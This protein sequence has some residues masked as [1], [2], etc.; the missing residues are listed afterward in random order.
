VIASTDW[1]TIASFATAVGTLVLAAATF[2]A[3]RSSNRSARIAEE[4][5][6]VNLRPVL[7]T[8]R[9]D[10]PM[11][12]LRWVD[13]HWARLDGS[14]ASVEM[15]NGSIYLA[16]SLRNVGPGLGVIFGWS[17]LTELV[18]TNEIPHAAPED[19]RMQTRDLYIAPGDIGFWQAAIREA[20]D[21][22]YAALSR[23]IQGVEG[24][25]IDVLY[26]DHEGGQRTITRFGMIPLQTGDDTK[27]FPNVARHWNLDR[28]D[29]R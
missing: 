8:S 21:P 3:V 22:D 5:F 20:G 14:Q 16:I 15:V 25:T 7:V 2:S 17:V 26:G 19:F 9:R 6:Q 1:A 27:W 29:P 11:Q 12:K 13:D 23:D 24:F 10:D 4:A 28:P 18:R